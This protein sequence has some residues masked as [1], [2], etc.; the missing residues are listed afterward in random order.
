M[1]VAS[2]DRWE[3]A[4]RQMVGRW[5]RILE[6]IEARDEGRVLELSNVMDEFCDEAMTARG[7]AAGSPGAALQAG[8][9]VPGPAGLKGTLCLFCRGFVEIGGCLGVLGELNRAVL[10]GHWGT[11]R[12]LAEQYIVRLE[13]LHL[14]GT[15]S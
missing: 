5:R 13:S 6:Q 8:F 1:T 11:A 7:S 12:R 14:E 15:A 10:G 3:L 9:K 4:R 2:E